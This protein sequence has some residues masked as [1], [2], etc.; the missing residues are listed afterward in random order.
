MSSWCLKVVKSG[1]RQELTEKILM[2]HLQII[3]I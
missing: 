3:D 1:E 2:G